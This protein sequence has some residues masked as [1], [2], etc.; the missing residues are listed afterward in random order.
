MF[1]KY[2]PRVFFAEDNG[3]DGGTGSAAA[4]ETAPAAAEVLT[5]VPAVESVPSLSATKPTSRVISVTE[6]L[7][8]DEKPSKGNARAAKELRTQ[9]ESSTIHLPEPPKAKAKAKAEPAKPA[10]TATPA[11]PEA[12]TGK[13]TP[14]P[15][16]AT[17]APEKPAE[18]TV[19]VK[20]QGKEYTPAELE[21]HV[22]ELEKAT[23]TATPAKPEAAAA[24][25]KTPEQQQAEEAAKRTEW[26]NN[27]SAEAKAEDI[28]LTEDTLDTILNGGKNAVEAFVGIIGKV[29]AKA[30]LNAREYAAQ[31]FNALTEQM[32]P[33][34]QREEQLAAYTAEQQLFEQHPDIKPAQEMARNISATLWEKF[35]KECAAMTQSEFNDEVASHVRTIHRQTSGLQP[36]QP[37]AA[38]LPA[39]TAP[40]PQPAAAAPA[41]AQPAAKPLPPTPTPP[42]GQVSGGARTGRTQDAQKAMVADLEAHTR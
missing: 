3:G 24:P 19:K 33:A 11:K 12:A 17:A 1:V 20:F 35:P 42:A 31:G 26:L 7:G 6:A 13:E 34:L 38:A 16:T 21:K 8:L 30:E 37:P 41:P 39:P 32:S 29:M 36:A 40:A 15:E 28:G 22:A 2:T 5:G 14:T 23:T 10:E 9:A 27:R 25:A 18:E 4:L